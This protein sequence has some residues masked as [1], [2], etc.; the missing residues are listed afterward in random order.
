MSEKL[1]CIVDLTAPENADHVCFA[2]EELQG[3]TLEQAEAWI[4]ANPDEKYKIMRHHDI[5]E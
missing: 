5:E 4:A 2:A 3:F 1:Y